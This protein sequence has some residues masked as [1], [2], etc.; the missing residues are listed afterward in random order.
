MF[1]FQAVGEYINSFL[2]AVKALIYMFYH[3]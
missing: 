2:P 3:L 1:F